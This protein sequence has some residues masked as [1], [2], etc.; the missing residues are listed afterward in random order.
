[1]MARFKNYVHRKLSNFQI[2]TVTSKLKNQ[3]ELMRPLHRP[4]DFAGVPEGHFVVV[5]DG[6]LLP[7]KRRGEQYIVNY[8]VV[9]RTVL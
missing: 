6:L 4:Y 1:M 7:K 5:Q 2:L 8:T 9:Q 3:Q